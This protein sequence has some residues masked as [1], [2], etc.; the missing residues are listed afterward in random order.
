MEGLTAHAVLLN[1]VLA[2]GPMHRQSNPRFEGSA[3]QRARCS[4][5]VALRAP[6][7]LNRNVEAVEL[8][9]SAKSHVI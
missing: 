7:P 1:P 4:V 3:E 6:A 2:L 9:I 5:P 8:S